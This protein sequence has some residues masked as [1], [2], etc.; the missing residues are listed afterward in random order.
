M[1]ILKLWKMFSEFCRV[2]GTVL[3]ELKCF[4]FWSERGSYSFYNGVNFY[5]T[6]SNFSTKS[7]RPKG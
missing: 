2:Q 7:S 4:R 3:N 1:I 5:F 6:V